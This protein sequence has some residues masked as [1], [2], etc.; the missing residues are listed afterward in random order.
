M[1]ERPPVIYV[2]DSNVGTRAA[3]GRLLRANQY[4]A[5]L[6]GSA[7]EIIG[8][9][10]ADEIPGCLILDLTM[11]NGMSGLELLERLGATGRL[12]PTVVLA[13]SGEP[14]KAFRAGKLGAYELLRKPVADTT[15]LRAIEDALAPFRSKSAA[16]RRQRRAQQLVMTLS[17]R[18]RQ[19]LAVLKDERTRKE[20]AAEIGVGL[21]TVKY[22]C[23][24]AFKKLGVHSLEAALD[25]WDAVTN[26]TSSV[27][28]PRHNLYGQ[29]AR[30]WLLQ[31]R[32]VWRR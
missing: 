27:A 9:A 16:A 14:E 1:A 24:N 4:Q 31:R 8:D 28:D 19:T 25:I 30:L 3:L 6:Y 22:Y 11:G 10:R 12:Y 26:E 21:S 23:N 18:E 5:R 17:A 7:E 20:A 2:V 13:A 32:R 29:R 15:I